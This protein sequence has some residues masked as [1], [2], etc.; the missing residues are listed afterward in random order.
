MQTTF[1]PQMSWR[2]AALLAAVW[3]GAAAALLAFVR[4]RF[5]DE[6]L[7]PQQFLLWGLIAFAG[8]PVTSVAAG[9]AH[10][11]WKVALIVLLTGAVLAI[12]SVDYFQ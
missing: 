11:S 3:L 5:F 10:R 8:P 4:L 12:F 9:T 7:D 1:R 6:N 2:R